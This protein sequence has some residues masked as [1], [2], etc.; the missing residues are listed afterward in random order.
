MRSVKEWADLLYSPDQTFAH[1]VP[2][3]YSNFPGGAVCGAE[4]DI[5]GW[6]GTGCWDEIETARSLPL[7]PKCEA[8]TSS[9]ASA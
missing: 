1:Y 2:F 5:D 8:A 3:G 9:K 4:P 7:C 6:F